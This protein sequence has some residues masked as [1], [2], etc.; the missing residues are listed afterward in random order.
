MNHEPKVLPFAPDEHY[1]KKGYLH[2]CFRVFRLKEPLKPVPFHYHDFHKIILFLGGSLSYCIEGRTYPLQPHDL[3]FVSAGEIH[4]PLPAGKTGTPYERIVIYIDPAFLARCR[5]GTDDLEAC[6]R[7]AREGSSVMKITT[8][9]THDLLYHMEKLERIAH[10]SGFANDIYTEIL[11]I[12]FMILVNRALLAHELD[13]LHASTYDSKIQH[14]LSYIQEHL[15]EPLSIDRIAQTAHLSKYYLMRKFKQETGCSL[16][17]YITSKRLLAARAALARSAESPEGL[18]ITEICYACGFRDYST[19]SR[20]FH[21]QFH[22]T[23]KEY[24]EQCQKHPALFTDTGDDL[25]QP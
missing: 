9:A 8:G 11:F 22:M 24:R 13:E 7:K 1:E 16:H 3:I 5:R 14:I 10:A 12:E 23:P 2:A 6:F 17:A 21:T 4:R 18:P 19:F 15:D 25:P 20:A